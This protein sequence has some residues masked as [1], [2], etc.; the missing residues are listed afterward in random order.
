MERMKAGVFVE[1]KFSELVDIK[2]LNSLIESLGTITGIGYTIKEI[3]D[4]SFV[5]IDHGSLCRDFYMKNE[6]TRQRCYNDEKIVVEKMTEEKEYIIHKCKNGL[7]QI[8]VPIRIDGCYLANIFASQMFLEEP[9]LDFFRSQGS[10]FGFDEKKYIKAVK[11]IPVIKREHLKP[12]IDFLLKVAKLVSEIASRHLNELEV[13]KK[14]SESY[15][16]LSAVYQQLRGAE[17][18]LRTQYDELEKMAYYDPLTGLPNWNFIQREL[19]K[20]DDSSL[21]LAIIYMD[22]DNFRGINNG[23]GHQCGDKLLRKIGETFQDYLKENCIVS[24]SSGDEFLILQRN[25]ESKEDVL[26]SINKIYNL[27]NSRW[28]LDEKEFFISG[29]I[30]IAIFPDDGDNFEEILRSADIA[31]N[32]SKHI[33]KNSHIFFEKSLYD[34]ISRRTEM[35]KELRN[36]IKNNELMLHYQ[37]QV[38]IKNGKIVSLEAL[39]RWNSKKFGWVSPYEF[40]K[41]AE[42]TGLIIPIGQWVLETACIQNKEWKS[43]GYS[44]DFISVNVS[45]TQIQNRDF[46]DNVKLILEQTG[47]KPEYLE[48]EITESV[49]METIESNLRI[50]N[51]LRNMGL[52][53]ALD[54]FGTGYSSLNYLKSLPINTLKLDKSFIDGLCSNSYEELITCE[55][56]K[57]AH[58]ME[59]DVTAEGVEFKNQLQSLVDKECN[60]IQ[61]YYFSKPFPPEEIE[62]DLKKG[63]FDIKL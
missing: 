54:D 62:F 26:E 25:V 45:V 40:I 28:E 4:E 39:L 14:L 42:D 36:A 3:K 34:Q 57:L 38:D 8:V 49:M 5:N 43:K 52:R 48:L 17:H 18:Q 59:L 27:I 29:S 2:H 13:N 37:P 51:E 21:K 50:L 24:R 15:I 7:E 16:E 46:L 41:L 10:Q 47:T 32:K 44:Y 19:N 12:I 6:S 9:N 56:I 35:E 55:I 53:I 33:G 31:L 60:R 11:E 30:G 63:F 20:Y 22:L 58:K 1:Y 23:F 61:G